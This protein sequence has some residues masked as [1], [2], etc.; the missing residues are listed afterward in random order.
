MSTTLSKILSLIVALSLLILH[1]PSI[2]DAE[3][4][5][6]PSPAVISISA[7]ERMYRDGLLPS[8]EP[9]QAFVKGDL[10]VPGTAFSCAS[11]HLRGGM[12]ATE[13]GVFTPPVTGQLLFQPFKALYKGLVQKYYAFPD[14]RPAYDNLTLAEVIRSGT[15]P[16]RSQLNDVMPRYMLED[17]DMAVLIEYLRT[18]SSQPAAGVSE[19]TLRFATIITDDVST[20]ERAALLEP[21]QQYFNIKNNQ[22]SAYKIN[23][24]RKSRQMAEN[25]LISKELS[26]RNLS[27]S[28][29]QLHGSSNTWRKQL[30]DYYR[31]EPVFALLGG[32]SNGSW[33]VIHTFC[34]ENKIPCLFPQTDLPVTSATDW[35]TL[36]LSKG[37]VQEGQA[38][39][40]FINRAD[41]DIS[42]GNILQL[43]KTTPTGNALAAGF[44]QTISEQRKVTTVAIN[45]HEHLTVDFLVKAIASTKPG[46]VVMW[47]DIDGVT[48][49]KSIMTN[50]K[51][52]Q[53]L[54]VSGRYLGNKLLSLP[55][56]LRSSTY[57]TYP[58]TFAKATV[59]GSMG[60]RILV[61]DESTWNL[62]S[63]QIHSY[64][65]TKEIRDNTETLTQILTMALMDMR[66]NYSRDVFFDAIGML[67][68]QPSNVYAR[69]S[70]GPG[71]RFASKG[72]YIVQ[73]TG[74]NT[75]SLA[76][77]SSWV[78]H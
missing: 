3:T 24:G 69:L 44:M 58:Y 5:S 50:K 59:P 27:L 63:S 1:I 31:N 62:L 45:A 34:E 18:L 26:T 47:D 74:S 77:K 48:A 12:G 20:E 56:S 7:G 22:A 29:W 51:K 30:D 19:T 32:I 67:Q 2:S 41:G 10:P 71:Q 23:S 54:F 43:V 61:E 53:A 25:M 14:R 11:C 75:P 37:Y 33:H 4:N 39:A 68:D 60:S 21:L 57:I 40:Q 38:A 64:N 8:G 76:R 49:L 35:Y 16:T 78:I 72:C 46:I 55:E 17:S 28:V 70:F 73:L 42:K 66:G 65:R 6:S 36:Y 52:P 15:T 9:I 13:G